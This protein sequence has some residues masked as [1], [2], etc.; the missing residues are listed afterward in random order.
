[1]DVKCY[2]GI[3]E[4]SFESSYYATVQDPKGQ[5]RSGNLLE[6]AHRPTEFAEAQ[7]RKKPGQIKRVREEQKKVTQF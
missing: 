2:A 6:T 1:V 4:N 7:L 3:A 5:S